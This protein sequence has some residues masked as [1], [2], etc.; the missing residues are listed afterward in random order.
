MCKQT[1]GRQA[2]NLKIYFLLWYYEC[3]S[4]VTIGGIGFINVYTGDLKTFFVD[5]II[6]NCLRDCWYVAL[7]A[8]E[9]TK[10]IWETSNARVEM[11]LAT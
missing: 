5:I 11:Q 4:F 9:D 10:K 6:C 2:G 3:C 8:Q 1:N 7:G